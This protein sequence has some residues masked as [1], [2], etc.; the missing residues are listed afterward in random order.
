MAPFPSSAY[1]QDQEHQESLAQNGKNTPV[2][3]V[4]SLIFLNNA[5]QCLEQK[6]FPLLVR[7]Q[8]SL[9]LME[10]IMKIPLKTPNRVT[11]YPGNHLSGVMASMPKRCWAGLSMVTA[12]LFTIVL[13]EQLRKFW[14]QYK[15]PYDANKKE[16]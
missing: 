4:M 8:I 12:A 6:C 14:S 11:I 7:I 5:V 15:H 16:R 1:L 10:N 2:K 9:L 3:L 13:K